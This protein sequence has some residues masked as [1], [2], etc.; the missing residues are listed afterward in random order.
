MR[1]ILELA[2]LSP[3][4]DDSI[5]FPGAGLYICFHAYGY[6]HLCKHLCSDFKSV[7]L[8]AL[9]RHQSLVSGSTDQ[10]ALTPAN[11]VYAWMDWVRLYLEHLQESQ[12]NC[13]PINDRYFCRDVQYYVFGLLL[14]IGMFFSA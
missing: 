9:Y 5:R 1:Q 13:I 8:H 12:A 14:Y 4:V 2:F 10:S 6:D 11:A 3:T 7:W